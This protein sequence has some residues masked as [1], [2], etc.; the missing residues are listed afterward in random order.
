MKA[1]REFLEGI[2]K[3]AELL[4]KE[5]IKKSTIYK[6]YVK[7]SSMA[8]A[9]AVIVSLILFRGQISIPKDYNEIPQVVRMFTLNDPMVNFYEADYVVIGETKKINKSQYVKEDNYIYTD[10]TIGVDE[11]FLGDIHNDEIILRIKGGKVEKEKVFSQMEGE[12]KKGKKS[13]LFLQKEKG[14]YYLVNGDES[15]FLEIEKDIFIDKQ[16][17]KYNMDNIKDNIDRREVN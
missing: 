5:K 3:K 9:I 7:I 11:I 17:N 1:N 14:I 13:L 15:Q 10:I 16:G 4:E 6:R 8:A 2:Y 12:F